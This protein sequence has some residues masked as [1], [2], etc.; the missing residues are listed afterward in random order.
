[1]LL[2]FYLSGTIETGLAVKI[3]KD[4]EVLLDHCSPPPSHPLHVEIASLAS[5]G[6][7]EGDRVRHCLNISDKKY[8]ELRIEELARE[9]SSITSI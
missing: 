1:M 8:S 2:V 7:E 4:G 3:T 9:Q 5:I 6:S